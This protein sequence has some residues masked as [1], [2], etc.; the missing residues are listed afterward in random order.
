M[1]KSGQGY[2]RTLLMLKEDRA[3]T[4]YHEKEER[5]FEDLV[6]N[7]FVNLKSF[8]KDKAYWETEVTSTYLK[9]L[10]GIHAPFIDTRF[11]EQIALFYY[12]IG[13]EFEIPEANEPLRDYAD[14]LVSQEDKGNIITVK[15]YAY[16]IADYFPI[17][18]EVTTHASMNHALG[19]MNI[20]LM[21]YQEFQD[22]RYLRTARRIQQAIAYQQDNWIRDNGDIW[23]RI[24]P[25][26]TFKGDD[27][28]HLTLEDLI[29]SYQLWQQF[30]P[31][32]LPYLKQL[33]INKATFLSN[34][35]LGYTPKIKDGLEQIGLSEYLPKGDEV[36]DAL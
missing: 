15:T 20:L 12:D 33:I 13:R 16:Y 35:N 19:G 18:Q 29:D 7:A 24:S 26:L 34:E 8:K 3:L 14:L 27:Y 25:D 22:P 36:T 11:N 4:L 17:N 1:P 31:V 28:K 2:G 10:Y 6:Y 21:A 23:Y 5:Y 30:D 9:D 32:Y